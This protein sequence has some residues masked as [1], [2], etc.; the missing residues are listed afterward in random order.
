M[1]ESAGRPHGELFV[2]PRRR[3]NR[4]IPQDFCG[5]NKE[6]DFADGTLIMQVTGKGVL[7]QIPEQKR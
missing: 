7:T 2:T 3:P 6:N 5:I 4:G 1:E